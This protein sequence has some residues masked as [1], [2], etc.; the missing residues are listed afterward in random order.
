MRSRWLSQGRR[1]CHYKLSPFKYYCAR[2]LDLVVWGWPDCFPIRVPDR[3]CCVILDLCGASPFSCRRL[4]GAAFSFVHDDG[5]VRTN[6][7][8]VPVYVGKLGRV[9][10]DDLWIEARSV[11]STEPI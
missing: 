7:E 3:G 5:R 8:A 9:G 4:L 10:N 6:V 11:S 2:L 1:R